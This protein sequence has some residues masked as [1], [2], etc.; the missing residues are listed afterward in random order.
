MYPNFLVRSGHIGLFNLIHIIKCT[1]VANAVTTWIWINT[2]IEINIS[3]KKNNCIYIIKLIKTDK[4]VLS[5][6]TLF[7]VNLI[8]T[9]GMNNFQSFTT[10]SR[11]YCLI[12]RWQCLL[13]LLSSAEQDP[14]SLDL[15]TQLFLIHNEPFSYSLLQILRNFWCWLV[16]FL[17][18]EISFIMP[19]VL[20]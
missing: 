8:C 4:N 16:I 3:Y 18:L 19:G 9:N 20:P 10:V 2:N 11:V 17:F 6:K 7:V 1:I 5:K 14:I 13:N 12:Y 15:N